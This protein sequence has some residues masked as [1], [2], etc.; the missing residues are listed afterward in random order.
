MSV[1]ELRDEIRA[2]DIQEPMSPW[3]STGCPLWKWKRCAWPT[4][5]S[6]DEPFASVGMG[7]PGS[8][9]GSLASRSIAH[10]LFLRKT[11][12]DALWCTYHSVIA[13]LFT[14]W[15]TDW[16]IS[17]IQPTSIEHL[18]ALDD[19]RGRDEYKASL[20]TQLKIQWG[21]QQYI[22][23]DNASRAILEVS[24]VSCGHPGGIKSGRVEGPAR[25]CNIWTFFC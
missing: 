4:R 22:P 18:C 8:I 25:G 15:L 17:F 2:F 9:S 7:Q 1:N 3:S 21:L 24:A 20:H 23:A 11:G 19:W 10:V 5:T 16:L 6:S 13:H 12:I 14:D